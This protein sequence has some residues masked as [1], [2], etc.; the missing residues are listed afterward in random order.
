MISYLKFNIIIFLIVA[1][2]LH[3]LNRILPKPFHNLHQLCLLLQIKQPAEAQGFIKGRFH[4]F[5]HIFD[6]TILLYIINDLIHKNNLGLIK[7]LVINEF[8]KGF[9]GSFVI[10]LGDLANEKTQGVTPNSRS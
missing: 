7:G 8:R 6:V 10:Q 4:E 1:T 9:H 5:R 2:H 3:H